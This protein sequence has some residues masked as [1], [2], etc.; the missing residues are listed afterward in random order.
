METKYKCNVCEYE[1]S[2]YRALYLHRQRHSANKV[3]C[4]ICGKE[5]LDLKTHQKIHGSKP[6]YPC[7]ICQK[8]LSTKR[9]K[10]RK[11]LKWH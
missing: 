4:N 6:T 9:A 5:V 7:N 3:N 10:T 2:S 1:G 11:E 8:K